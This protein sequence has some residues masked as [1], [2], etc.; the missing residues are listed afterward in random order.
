MLSKIAIIT[1]SNSGIS[2]EE[3][4]V[5]GVY[6]LPM[7]FFVDG[8]MHYEGVDFTQEDFYQKL[9]EDAEMSTSMPSPGDIMD[10]WDKALEENDVVLHIPMSSGLSGSCEAAAGFAKSDYEGKVLVVDNKRIFLTLKQSILEAIALREAGKSAKEIKEALEAHG[11][12]SF[13]YFSVDTLKYLK[14]GGR[15]SPAAAAIGTVLNLKPV[16]VY[17]GE[18]MEPYEKARGSKASRR[19]I[20]KGVEAEM[21][22][23]FGE[24]THQLTF[25][26][27]YTCTEDEVQK[28]REEVVAHFSWLKKEEIELS[29]I[30]ISVACHTGPGVVALSCTKKLSF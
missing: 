12:E 16:L 22:E 7:P 18:K 19:A 26:I 21:K 25:T 9:A 11:P 6:V 24:E 30:S 29:R 2:P 5:L 23:R 8:V 20:L 15:I 4:K 1:D 27:P 17:R 13:I 3:A 10:L 28:W 14:K